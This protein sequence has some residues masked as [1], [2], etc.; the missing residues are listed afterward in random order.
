VADRARCTQPWLVLTGDSLFVGAA[1]R[2]DLA[3]EATEGARDLYASL[4]RLLELDDGVEIYPGHVAGSLCGAS[5]SSKPSS[6]IGFERR[7]NAVLARNDEQ[8]FVDELTGDRTPRPP[9]LER[10]VDLNRGP[11]LGAPDELEETAAP[12]GELVID[13]RAADAFAAGHI[14]GVINVPLTRSGF[15]TRAG[16][17]LP[18]DEPLVL[19]AS[20]PSDANEAARRLAAVGFQQLAGY[21]LHPPEATE[22]IPTVQVDELERLLENDEIELVDVRELNERDDGYIPGSRHIPY[23]LLHAYE[24]ELADGKPIVTICESGARAAVGASMLAAAGVDA[25]PVIHGG[26]PDWNARG[27]STVKFRRC[28][29]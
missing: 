11:F 1:A 12:N 5:M 16:F 24:D 9:T 17:V 6:T 4:Q 23:R 27:K 13:V 28:G 29:G 20:T 14:R 7:F 22:T 8:E 10:V 26:I 3:I 15:G 18:L 21:V 19:H 2:P 25:R